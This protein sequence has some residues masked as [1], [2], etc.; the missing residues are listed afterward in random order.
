MGL[1][2]AINENLSQDMDNSS[3]DNSSHRMKPGLLMRDGKAHRRTVHR[4]QGARP[5]P[6]F[7]LNL[8]TGPLTFLK[9][10]R[11]PPQ[12][13]KIFT[14]RSWKSHKLNNTYIR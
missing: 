11:R 7:F 13:K 12:F 1:N 5:P 14:L 2:A 4:G 8:Q 6:P 9:I 3:I 10:C